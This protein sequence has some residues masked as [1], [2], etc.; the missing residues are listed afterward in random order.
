MICP[1]CDSETG[2]R[3]T[4]HRE[5]FILRVRFCLGGCG[6]TFRTYELPAGDVVGPGD[7]PMIVGGNAL[8]GVLSML[9]EALGLRVTSA[10]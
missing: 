4:R 10:K 7:V 6:H 1:Q 3:E 9:A 5:G 2:V 8:H